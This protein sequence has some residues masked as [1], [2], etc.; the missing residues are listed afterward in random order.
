MV[1]AATGT[2]QKAA[3]TRARHDQFDPLSHTKRA[4]CLKE[5][6]RLQVVGLTV[7][8]LMDYPSRVFLTQFAKILIEWPMNRPVGVD[9]VTCRPTY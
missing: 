5:Y 7:F 2:Q 6:L 3:T 1:T 9:G 4:A 8:R